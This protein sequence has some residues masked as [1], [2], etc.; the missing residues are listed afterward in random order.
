M[1][2]PKC[3]IDATSRSELEGLDE[4]FLLVLPVAGIIYKDKSVALYRFVELLGQLRRVGVSVLVV[5]PGIPLE[6]G[7]RGARRPRVRRRHSEHAENERRDGRAGDEA[8]PGVDLLG[9]ERRRLG[10]G[11]DG[12]VRVRH[13]VGVSPA[14]RFGSHAA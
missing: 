8:L 11:R 13:D 10:R 4:G 7:L 5:A 2:K 6:H 9:R 3:A 12:V 1:T 14:R